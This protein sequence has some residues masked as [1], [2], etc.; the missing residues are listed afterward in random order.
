TSLRRRG[1]RGQERR[2]IS[3]KYQLHRNRCDQ[4]PLRGELHQSGSD[5]GVFIASLMERTPAFRMI[6]TACR[7]RSNETESG[8]FSKTSVVGWVRTACVS[9]AVSSADEVATPS[10]MK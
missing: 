7:T 10:W 8:T 5:A 6:S 4:P 2:L 3:V 1:H 9:E